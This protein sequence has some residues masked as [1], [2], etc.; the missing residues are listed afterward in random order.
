MRK[1][2]NWQ[3]R[4]F[5]FPPCIHSSYNKVYKRSDFLN[6]R[7]MKGLCC[8]GTLNTTLLPLYI[9]KSLFMGIVLR[10]FFCVS[11]LNSD[12]VI[13]NL[14]SSLYFLVNVCNLSKLRPSPS[15]WIKTKLGHFNQT[16]HINTKRHVSIA[17]RLIASGLIL[18][19]YAFSLNS[20]PSRRCI[21]VL[22]NTTGP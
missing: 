6:V 2:S 10:L 15:W 5:H 18:L 1:A 22:W 7:S 11:L 17:G 14:Q 21:W 13:I 20:E 4:S 16:S 3:R 9:M 12:K 8:C 19:V